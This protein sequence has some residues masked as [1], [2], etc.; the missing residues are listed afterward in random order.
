MNNNVYI[1]QY[2]NI[3]N[4]IMN[5]KINKNKNSFNYYLLE[6]IYILIII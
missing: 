5:N 2:I 1:K 4:N 3:G 6:I